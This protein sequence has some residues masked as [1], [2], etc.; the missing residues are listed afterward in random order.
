MGFKNPGALLGVINGGVALT[1]VA[2][3]LAF[4]LTPGGVILVML[5]GAMIELAGKASDD[6]FFA[7]VR[8]AETTRGK[9]A[10]VF[11]R[12]DNDDGFAHLFGLH[13]SDD[14]R[15]GATVDDDLV[16]LSCSGYGKEEGEKEGSHGWNG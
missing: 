16:V 6:F 7:G 11:I 5:P 4:L 15:A 13:R 3:L 2:I 8:P 12:G 14:S 1:F 10:E 9:A